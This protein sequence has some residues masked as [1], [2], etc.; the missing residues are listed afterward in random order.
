MGD[1]HDQILRAEKKWG[2]LVSHRNHHKKSN[3]L[4]LR[5]RHLQ[6]QVQHLPSCQDHLLEEHDDKQSDPPEVWILLIGE[7]LLGEDVQFLS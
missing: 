5:I 2:A 3:E 4:N 1:F 7:Q 6:H